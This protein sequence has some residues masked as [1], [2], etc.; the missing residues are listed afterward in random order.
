MEKK[1]SDLRKDIS[2][3]KKMLCMRRTTPLPSSLPPL[4][5]SASV[6]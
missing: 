6:K 5:K 1:L 2:R 3:Q 4:K